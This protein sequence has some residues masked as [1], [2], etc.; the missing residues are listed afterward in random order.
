MQEVVGGP[1]PGA[2]ELGGPTR[3]DTLHE[4]QLTLQRVT[5]RGP[6]RVCVHLRWVT[7]R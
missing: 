7:A 4:P 1:Q 6:G 3:A 5:L 2:L